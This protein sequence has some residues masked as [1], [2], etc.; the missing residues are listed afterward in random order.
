M[1]LALHVQGGGCCGAS[2]SL[3]HSMDRGAA[4][5]T[6]AAASWWLAAPGHHS[7]PYPQ[8]GNAHRQLE[9]FCQVMGAAVRGQPQC[10]PL[11]HCKVR[12]FRPL[13]PINGISLA[14]N[15]VGTCSFGCHLECLCPGGPH[16]YIAQVGFQQ[17]QDLSHATELSCCCAGQAPVQGS[18]TVVQVSC[19]LPAPDHIQAVQASGS[20]NA[21]VHWA[22]ITPTC[23]LLQGNAAGKC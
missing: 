17:D 19:Q 5:S 14:H 11:M 20:Q 1:L 9:Q 15:R 7:A 21:V 6:A 12:C 18:S 3:S 2:Q 8:P 4:A 16:R 23:L 13:L 22:V 10:V